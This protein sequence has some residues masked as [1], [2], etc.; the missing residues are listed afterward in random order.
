MDFTQSEFVPNIKVGHTLWVKRR[1]RIHLTS[2][3]HT[4]VFGV[5]RETEAPPG[6]GDL[7]GSHTAKVKLGSEVSRGVFSTH[8]YVRDFYQLVFKDHPSRANHS[9][10]A[11]TW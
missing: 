6:R 10:K 7:P 11:I 2:S 3:P 5:E 8:S 9:F 1:R 4:V